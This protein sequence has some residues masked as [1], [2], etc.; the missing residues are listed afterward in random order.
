MFGAF[1][2][3]VA[4]RY[5]RARKGERF[6]SVIAIFSLVGIALANVRARLALLHDVQGEFTAGVQKQHELGHRFISYNLPRDINPRFNQGEKR[7]GIVPIRMYSADQVP[8]VGFYPE[9]GLRLYG[10]QLRSPDGQY[11]EAGTCWGATR[12]RDY[13]Q[14]IIFDKYIKQY[15]NDG[16]YLDGAGLDAG[17][18]DDGAHH[19][20]AQHGGLGVVEGA[21]EGLGQRGTRG[22]DDDGFGHAGWLSV[23]AVAAGWKE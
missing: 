18:L 15:G 14:H 9:V 8:P 11:S 16:M 13:E 1:E 4:F 2:R 6:V 20:A 21:P 19:V 17:P 12:W 10:D 22:G 7:I 5:L 23:R 3:M